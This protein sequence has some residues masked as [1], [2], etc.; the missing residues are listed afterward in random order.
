MSWSDMGI[1]VAFCKYH[2][3]LL[4]FNSDTMSDVFGLIQCY[5]ALMY[6]TTSLFRS[7]EDS[8]LHVTRV[9]DNREITLAAVVTSQTKYGVHQ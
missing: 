2:D 6:L 5:R 8:V 1:K 4:L 9:S 7:D 3:L